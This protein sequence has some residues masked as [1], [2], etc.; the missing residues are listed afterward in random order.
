MKTKVT[1]ALRAVASSAADRVGDKYVS[2]KK[3]SSE[4]DIVL[5]PGEQTDK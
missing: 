4:Y 5:E 1:F 3:C 2:V